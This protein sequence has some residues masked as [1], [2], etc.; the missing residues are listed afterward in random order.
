[1]FEAGRDHIGCRVQFL[2]V[3][4]VQMQGEVKQAAATGMGGTLNTCPDPRRVMYL[5]L[6]NT[7]EYFA[8]IQFHSATADMTAC[9]GNCVAQ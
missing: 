8:L 3:Q 9:I 5:L 2:R 1:M 4:V 7:F 6:D